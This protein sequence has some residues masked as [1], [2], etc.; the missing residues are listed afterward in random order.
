MKENPNTT[1]TQPWSRIDLDLHYGFTNSEVGLCTW[2]RR[3]KSCQGWHVLL[4]SSTNHCFNHHKLH[5]HMTAHQPHS[6]C[7]QARGVLRVAPNLAKTCVTHLEMHVKSHLA[8]KKSWNTIWNISH[9]WYVCQ[10][11]KAFWGL[12][13]GLNWH[14]LQ[15]SLR[16]SILKSFNHVLYYCFELTSLNNH[17]VACYCKM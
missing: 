13:R 17:I 16:K 7:N 1:L 6:S 8:F 15:L 9:T 5:K 12:M 11:F 2:E 10:R 4:Q 3:T 14:F